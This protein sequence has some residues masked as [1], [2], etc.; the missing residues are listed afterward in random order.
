MPD[1]V[2]PAGNGPDVLAEA[3]ESNP[4]SSDSTNSLESDETMAKRLQ[5]EEDAAASTV[6]ISELRQILPSCLKA[7]YS[8]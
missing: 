7:Y 2:V 4:V 6:L 8:L 5:S 3:P 1:D